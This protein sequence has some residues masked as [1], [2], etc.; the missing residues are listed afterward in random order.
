MQKQI[1]KQTIRPSRTKTWT[2]TPIWMLTIFGTLRL[3]NLKNRST[4]RNHCSTFISCSSNCQ[5]LKSRTFCISCCNVSTYWHCMV[6]HCPMQHEII[7]DSSFG[8]K[9]IYS[10]KS[11]CAQM[12]I[13]IEF[14]AKPTKIMFNS[15]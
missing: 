6:M 7:E 8:V 3:E 13:T 1:P 12:T 10:S 14:H 5:T 9:R 11:T 15:F 2:K 4:C